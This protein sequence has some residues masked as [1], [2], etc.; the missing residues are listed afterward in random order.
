MTRAAAVLGA[1]LVAS[2]F[3][4][5][6]RQAT[7]TEDAARIVSSL[8]RPS[9]ARTARAA[10]LLDHAGTLNP[11][12]QVDLLRAQLDLQRGDRAAARRRVERVVGDEPDN[13]DAWTRLAFV[14]GRG[15]PAAFAR[16]VREVRRLAPVV[17]AP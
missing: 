14:V 3:A 15:D 4:L 7:S 6:V 5:G 17:P 10:R 13:I 11:D 2:W 16:A 9:A 12:R 8:D 1:L